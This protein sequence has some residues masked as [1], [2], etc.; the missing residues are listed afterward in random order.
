MNSNG[1]IFHFVLW[2]SKRVRIYGSTFTTTC[3]VPE[4]Y[5]SIRH[6]VVKS[7]S[8]ICTSRFC[9]IQLC[10][11][12]WC[13]KWW[14]WVVYIPSSF[15]FIAYHYRW[16]SFKYYYFHLHSWYLLSHLLDFSK[17]LLSSLFLDYWVYT[18][19]IVVVVIVINFLLILD[20]LNV[21]CSSR[22]RSRRPRHQLSLDFWFSGCV[23]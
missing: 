22:S 9:H 8:I 11:V 15:H 2:L 23:L 4:I 13:M 21:H 6:V 12:N 17:S 14:R 18:V 7:T 20:F 1:M 16:W 10:L 19:A 3:T 5:I